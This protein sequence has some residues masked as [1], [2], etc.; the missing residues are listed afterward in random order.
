MTTG[1][2]IASFGIAYIIAQL[3]YSVIMTS[4][5]FSGWTGMGILIGIVFFSLVW[6]LIVY[7]KVTGDK[8]E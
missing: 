3:I 4:A 6:G 7:G 1:R 8:D 5:D 2:G